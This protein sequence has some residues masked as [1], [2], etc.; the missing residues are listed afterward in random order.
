LRKA[1]RDNPRR[2]DLN[3][4]GI[5]LVAALAALVLGSFARMSTQT[6][7][8]EVEDT[9][10]IGCEFL[11]G[12]IDGDDDRSGGADFVAACDGLSAADIVNL[13]AVLGDADDTL[14][15]TDLEDDDLDANQIQDLQDADATTPTGTGG[16]GFTDETYVIA[17]VDDD[18][19]VTFDADAG[20]T[21][22]V[23]VDGGGY[24]ADA[25]L[26]AETCAGVD[27]LDCDAST[28]NSDD[29][30][31]VVVATIMDATADDGDTVDVDV[32]QAD[33]TDVVSSQTINVM[34]AADEVEL[35]AVETTIGVSEDS[36]AATDCVEEADVTD[37]TDQ[38]ADLNR[39][40]LIA[41][42]TDN[43][44]DELTRIGVGFDAEAP[45]LID[46][47]S[48]FAEA[49]T[50]LP[51]FSSGITV[52]G[53]DAG[54]AAFAVVCADDETGDGSVTATI[55][56]GTAGEEDTTVDISVVGDPANVALTA[57]PAII[58][59]NGV[60]TSTVS[61]TVTDADGNNVTNGTNVNFSVVAL[62]TANP[63]NATTTDGVASSTITPLS[64]AVAGVTVIVTAG[65]A[66]ASIRVDCNAPAVT[67]GAGTP[68]ATPTRSGIGGPD[69]GTGGYADQDSAGFP[70]W[71]LAALGLGSLALVG[72]GL[73]ARRASK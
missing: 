30:D 19:V 34:G 60:A 66:Q 68:V 71:M 58:D 53:G 1:P 52:D 25:D 12:A 24:S 27:D 63:I 9:V 31:G 39:T 45:I 47:E 23:N 70:L 51:A 18:Q 55:N 10:V 7:N 56:A 6:A 5:V 72:G 26:N 38:L 43:D 48:S 49:G 62:G 2:N 15:A 67:P 29:G 73:V 21:V 28:P 40:V 44:G 42:V 4:I 13:A 16:N 11:A 64:N 22:D 61:A 59:C 8:A 32:D 3:K 50:D 37:A 41:T 46:D 57:S 54:I 65:D 33:D 14:E 20:V 69:T 36:T 35:I 17:F